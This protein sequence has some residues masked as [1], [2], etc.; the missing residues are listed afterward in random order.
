[1]RTSTL[2]DKKNYKTVSEWIDGSSAMEESQNPKKPSLNIRDL[3][4]KSIFQIIG[5]KIKVCYLS[6]FCHIQRIIN[7]NQYN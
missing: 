7:Q 2:P 1:M 6:T 3:A 5:S 4:L